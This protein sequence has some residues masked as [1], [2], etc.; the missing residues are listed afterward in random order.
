MY[1]NLNDT[2]PIESILLQEY[3]G[4]FT[5][6]QIK[7]LFY[8]IRTTTPDDKG[9]K[10]FSIFIDRSK[11]P[12]PEDFN[13]ESTG[14]TLDLTIGRN[15]MLLLR[16]FEEPFSE[17]LP[18]ITISLNKDG[19]LNS[20][21]EPKKNRNFKQ[22]YFLIYLFRKCA[23]DIGYHLEFYNESLHV[24]SSSIARS[25][26]NYLK[27]LED[28]YL[29]SGNDILIQFNKIVNFEYIKGCE[30]VYENKV[31]IIPNLS[32]NVDIDRNLLKYWA[33]FLT[34]SGIKIALL[35]GLKRICFLEDDGIYINIQF[36][37]G[38]SEVN[39]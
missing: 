5:E 7:T 27:R 37:R 38:S 9:N 2:S 23:Q 14:V 39:N 33:A 17:D 10:L 21:L 35:N 15:G 4:G 8:N 18:N 32:G 20:K 30:I 36:G 13:E 11:F 12:Y 3:K 31:Y 19:I 29:S 26:Y 34:Y 6:D 24:T 25:Y 22:C 16:I 1:S 28:L